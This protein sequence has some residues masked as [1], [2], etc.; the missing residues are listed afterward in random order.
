MGGGGGWGLTEAA[1]RPPRRTQKCHPDDAEHLDDP[2]HRAPF[3]R[4]DGV[5]NEIRIQSCIQNRIQKDIQTPRSL[6]R[7]DVPK[8]VGG[9]GV[10]GRC[11]LTEAAPSRLDGRRSRTA[12]E[13]AS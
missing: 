8:G 2:N 3:G 9:G 13:L 11:G 10:G 6:N 5:R 7:I 1:P 4:D 12:S